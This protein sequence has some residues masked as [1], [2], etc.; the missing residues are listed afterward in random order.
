MAGRW[1]RVYKRPAPRLRRGAGR[2]D[3]QSNTTGHPPGALVRAAAAPRVPLRPVER[4]RGNPFPPGVAAAIILCLLQRA[5]ARRAVRSNAARAR[6]VF[7]NPAPWSLP[8][9]APAAGTKRRRFKYEMWKKLQLFLSRTKPAIRRYSR[10]YGKDCQCRYRQKEQNLVGYFMLEATPPPYPSP[11]NR[12]HPWR[13]F[14]K[15]A[16]LVY[17]SPSRMSWY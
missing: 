4:P 1:N 9:G 14:I 11:H 12:S 15:F 5:G 7:V 3:F 13:G 10:S 2:I 6:P 17:T 8:P 16:T